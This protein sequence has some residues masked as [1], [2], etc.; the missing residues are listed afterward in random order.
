MAW[1]SAGLT[2]KR[3]RLIRHTRIRLT[4]TLNGTTGI[5][6]TFIGNSLLKGSFIYAIYA[7]TVMAKSSLNTNGTDSTT[8]L[9]RAGSSAL[10]HWT[11]NDIYNQQITNVTNPAYF[12]IRSIFSGVTP[13]TN[14][15][16]IGDTCLPMPELRITAVS[17]NA[18]Q[19][20][21]VINVE[22][23]LLSHVL[24]V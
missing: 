2:S 5:N 23:A 15:N 19:T 16:Y 17:S 4:G 11:E 12:D 22:I 24:E 8:L 13:P 18:A 14:A 1:T 10:H 21:E 9:I 6:Y 20:T 3:G 7:G